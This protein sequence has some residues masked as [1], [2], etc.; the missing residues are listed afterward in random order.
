MIDTL[1]GLEARDPVA[2]E[3]RPS[4]DIGG[5]YGWIAYDRGRGHDRQ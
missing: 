2:G 1:G 3:D 4:P 5:R